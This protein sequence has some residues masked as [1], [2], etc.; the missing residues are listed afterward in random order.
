M[1]AQAGYSGMD[2]LDS[3]AAENRDFRSLLRSR[4][5][6]PTGPDYTSEQLRKRDKF[7][8]SL[9]A[10]LRKEPRKRRTAKDPTKW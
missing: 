1:R 3:D 5:K 7:Q 10:T 9:H 4:A 8:P 2:R 6:I